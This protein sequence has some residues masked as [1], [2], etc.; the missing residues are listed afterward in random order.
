MPPWSG[1]RNPNPQSASVTTQ[2][3]A[4][5]PTTGDFFYIISGVWAVVKSLEMR[6]D[7]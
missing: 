7:A 5:T 4:A 3:L 2:L 6:V 1:N